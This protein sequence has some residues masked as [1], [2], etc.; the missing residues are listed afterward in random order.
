[1]AQF[2]FTTT[3]HI[4][5]PLA[6]VCDAV[7]QCLH[8]PQWWP[9]VQ[10]V[11]EVA[12]GDSDGIGSVRRFTWKGPLPYRLS[13]DVRVVR[14]VPLTLLEGEASGEVEG[15]GRWRFHHAGGIT[16]VC[17][18]W[19]VRTKRRWMT[20]FSPMAW[21]LFKWNHDHVMRQGAEGMA[22]LLNARLVSFMH[23]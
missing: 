6:Q 4:E 19:E 11:H 5:A 9:A 22:R 23:G 20:V 10:A 8:W 15:M 1:M 7:S 3:W 13:F 18:E 14:V 17:Y 2:R 16:A 12:A 21:P